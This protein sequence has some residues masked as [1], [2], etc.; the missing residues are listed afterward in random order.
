ML[1]EK[2]AEKKECKTDGG[3]LPKVSIIIPMYNEEKTAEKT[4]KSALE[5]TYPG[6]IEIVTIDDGSTDSTFKILKKMTMDEGKSTFRRSMKI[7]KQNNGGKPAALNKG[8]EISTGGIVISTDGDSSLDKKAVEIIVKRFMREPETGA[9]SGFIKIMN[10]SDSWIT[11]LSE[12]EYLKEQSLFRGCQSITGDVVICPGAFFAARKN[13]L[14]QNPSDD[15]TVVED[16]E[17]TCL[18]RKSGWKIGFEPKAISETRAPNNL[19][20]WWNQRLRWFYGYLQVW[21]ILKNFGKRK[22][23][24]VYGYLGYPMTFLSLLVMILPIAY[25]LAFSMSN[26]L[27]SDIAIYILFGIS[28]SIAIQLYSL[29]VLSPTKIKKSTLPW[30]LM[31]PVYEI[32]IMSMRIYLYIMYLLSRGPVMKY[33]PNTVR[34]L[35]N[36]T[37]K[38]RK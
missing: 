4:I 7:V 5:Q 1:K 34:A 38:I 9:I 30:I 2:K 29:F 19:K 25:V 23:W 36:G 13:A 28:L 18:I 35:P 17:Q 20:S 16:C 27:M 14:L 33:G 32:M 21:C 15:I 8:I 37:V 11:K 24:M 26:Y 3:T 31:F 6:F 22:P 10:E 12:I